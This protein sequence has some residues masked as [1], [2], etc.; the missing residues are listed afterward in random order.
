MDLKAKFKAIGNFFKKPLKVMER[1]LDQPIED[2]AERMQYALQVASPV[3]ASPSSDSLQNSWRIRRAG[4]LAW[5]IFSTKDPIWLRPVEYGRRAAPVPIEP[6][7]PWV[8]LK[9]NPD[10]VAARGIAIAISRKKAHTP[11][12][13]QGFVRK[14]VD[15]ELP[16]IGRLIRG[17]IEVTALQELS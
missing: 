6:L 9:I 3:G 8:Q 1:K 7:I 4:L 15:E 17:R 13:G 5:E 11:T 2:A 10:P 16:K 14:T 12:P